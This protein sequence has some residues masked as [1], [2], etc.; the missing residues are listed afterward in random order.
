VIHNARTITFVILA[1][2]CTQVVPST[3]VEAQPRENSTWTYADHVAEMDVVGEA[4]IV[5]RDTTV[6]VP[7]GNCGAIGSPVP[8]LNLHLQTKRLIAG[9]IGTRTILLRTL[10]GYPT[11]EQA[12][13]GA[14]VFFWGLRVCEDDWNLW[15]KCLLVT[16]AGNVEVSP[17]LD[18]RLLMS[19]D[20]SRYLNADETWI[21]LGQA[22]KVGAM[23]AFSSPQ[24]LVAVR[25]AN[26]ILD[27][28]REGVTCEGIR[29]D[30][31]DEV[32]P[33]T[34]WIAFA[35]RQRY[36]WHAPAVGDTLVVPVTNNATSASIAVSA[37]PDLCAV[38]NGFIR[39]LG[40]TYDQRMTAYRRVS[41]G[42][43][44]KPYHDSIEPEDAGDE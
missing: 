19:P 42:L 11:L 7:T 20:G 40:V 43:R 35:P 8:V 24:A 22:V 33:K 21:K 41:S 38:R 6:W 2:L 15:G 29:I 27:A 25:V 23:R 37:A 10:T 34:L 5:S 9:T 3:V 31:H 17:G 30:D 36:G 44:L 14:R 26:V 12:A 32:S 4:T 39:G 1:L 13:P 18:R 16:A 28:P